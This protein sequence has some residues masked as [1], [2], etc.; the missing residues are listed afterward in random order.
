[1]VQIFFLKTPKRASLNDFF[2]FKDILY[3]NW[4]EKEKILT[5]GNTAWF[6]I[7]LQSFI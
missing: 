7:K 2:I 3:N 4:R 5:V 6:K 1:M